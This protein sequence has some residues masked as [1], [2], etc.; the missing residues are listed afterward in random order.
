MSKKTETTITAAAFLA[1]ARTLA[2][3][4]SKSVRVKTDRNGKAKGKP[5]LAPT[6]AE[7]KAWLFANQSTLVDAI[8]AVKA[9]KAAAKAAK[10]TKA[11]PAG[12]SV[13]ASKVKTLP[14]TDK[15]LVA[16]AAA[17][18]KRASNIAAAARGL[19]G[20]LPTK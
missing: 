20:F 1:A 14:L 3:T 7:A 13:Y 12:A 15:K 10:E 17:Q 8:A 18:M 2:A 6:V 11:L 4:A 5:T 9:A 19:V 16:I